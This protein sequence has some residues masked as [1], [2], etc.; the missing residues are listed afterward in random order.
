[1]KSQ[2]KAGHESH[3]LFLTLGVVIGLAIGV[4]ASSA[5][6]EDGPDPN[7]AMCDFFRNFAADV[8]RM[9]DRGVPEYKVNA[10]NDRFFDIP[11]WRT[12]TG[13][14]KSARNVTHAVFTNLRYADATPEHVGAVAY[15]ACMSQ[16][17]NGQ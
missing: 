9:R 17:D 13:A 11:F 8:T 12:A 15:A 7:T 16:P 3:G 14:A 6:A 5:H 2:E 4:Y 1:M 10:M